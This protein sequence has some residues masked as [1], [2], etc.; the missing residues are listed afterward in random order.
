M[1][2]GE[3]CGTGIECGAEVTIHLDLIKGVSVPRPRLETAQEIMCVASAEGLDLAIKTS[4]GDMVNWL[5]SEKGLSAEEAYV[6][7]SLAGDVRIGQIV[8]SSSDSAYCSPQGFSLHRL[9][10]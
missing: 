1:G 2:D 5:Q 3:V 10:I 8:R 4:L 9:R 6:L 7:V